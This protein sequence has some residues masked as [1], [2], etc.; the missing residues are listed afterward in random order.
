MTEEF[1]ISARRRHCG[2]CIFVN[3]LEQFDREATGLGRFDS[4]PWCSENFKRQG[5]SKAFGRALGIGAVMNYQI[6]VCSREFQRIRVEIA[7]NC[8]ELR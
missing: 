8:E 7:R 6:R 5:K 3:C 4:R 2:G 1:R